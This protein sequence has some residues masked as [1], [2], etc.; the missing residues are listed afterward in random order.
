MSNSVRLG[1]VGLGTMGCDLLKEAA[2]NSKAKIIAL[3]DIDAGALT[4][5][6][7]IIG[8]PVTCFSDYVE[9][10][11]KEPL[12][13]VIIAVPQDLHAVIS[14]ASL[15]AKY[16][17]FCEKPMALTTAQCK[18]V[19]ETSKR[20]GKGIM[21]GQVL[22]YIGPYRYV[23]EL[24]TS[25]ELGEAVAMRTIRTMGKWGSWSR[26]WR[27]KRATCGGLLLEVNVHEIDLMLRILGEA[28]S[29]SA[30]GKNFINDEVDYEDFV[31]AQIHFKN[32]GIGTIT[33][34]CCDALGRNSGEI[35][36][37]GGTIYYDSLSQAVYVGRE[38]QER[39]VIPYAEIYPAGESGVAREVRE[40][41]E[42]C[43]GEGPITIP[44][45]DGLR[46]VEI[47][48]AAYQSIA[49]GAPVFLS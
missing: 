49:I 2:Q 20:I 16:T 12:D 23:L 46:A 35:Y 13:G 5:A 8:Q 4:R 33:S 25:G 14:I 21:I 44:G 26:P 22:R 30:V 38:G 32:G 6:E 43:L 27:L 19:I 7:E 3:C 29:V 48:E 34:G 18:Q 28:A 11:R 39:Q 41:I 47:G 17:T 31:N 1:F 42:V 24:A 40:F 36:L 9:M 45:E 15:E 37:T 10:F